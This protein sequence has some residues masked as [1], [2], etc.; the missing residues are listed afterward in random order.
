[1]KK[2]RFSMLLASVVVSGTV[3]AV[4]LLEG[5][6]TSKDPKVRDCRIL[7]ADD[8]ERASALR[9]VARMLRGNGVP[10]DGLRTRTVAVH[11]LSNEWATLA[12]ETKVRPTCLVYAGDDGDVARS[13]TRIYRELRQQKVPAELHL[14]SGWGRALEK[15]GQAPASADAGARVLEFL[16][17]M[18]VVGKLGGPVSQSHRWMPG[19]TI[20]TEKEP[21]WPKG[22]IPDAAPN[23]GYDPY[24]VWFVPEKPTTKAIQIV[25]PGGGY[26]SCNFNGEGTPLAYWLNGKGMTCVVVMYRCPRAEGRPKHFCAWQDAQRAIRVVRAGAPARGLDPNRIGILGFSAGGHLTLVTA[27]GA[28]TPAYRPVDAIDQLPCTVQW[29]CPIYPAYALAGD[30]GRAN[31][32][33]DNAPDAAPAPELAFDADTPPMCFVHGDADVYSPMSSVVCW[34]RL[35]RMGIPGD[36]HTLATRGHCFQ[37]AASPGTGSST[38]ADRLWEFLSRAGFNR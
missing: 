14:T 25:F 5:T 26:N 21:L 20:R 11:D 8:D 23:Q 33:G 34:E 28:R 6:A 37:M 10:E 22:Q 19:D 35:R 15:R 16:R 27:T 24:L 7:V 13:L 29:A 2:I 32:K 18:E 12:S 31:G 30:A 38:W 17:Q 1:M 36:L 4:E 3:W 9:S